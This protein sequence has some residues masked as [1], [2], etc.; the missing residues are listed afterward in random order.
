MINAPQT[1]EGHQAW[2][3]AMHATG[4]H[5]FGRVV[6]PAVDTGRAIGVAASLGYDVR[7]V[8]WLVTAIAVG[9]DQAAR[10]QLE[11]EADRADRS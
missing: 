10:N 6:V 3:A 2:D 9:V 11:Q 4:L 8:A 5:S 7:A 1:V